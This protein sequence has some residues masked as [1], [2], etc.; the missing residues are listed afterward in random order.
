MWKGWKEKSLQIYV[1]NNFVNEPV[2]SYKNWLDK[3]VIP[4]IRN[5]VEYVYNSLR[6]RLLCI[7]SFSPS[8][9]SQFFQIIKHNFIISLYMLHVG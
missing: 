8:I 4:G 7:I 6:T 9:Y 3:F 1:A 2:A 5:I